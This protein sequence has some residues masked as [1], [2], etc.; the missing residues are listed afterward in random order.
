VAGLGKAGARVTG[1][2]NHLGPTA[3][4]HVTTGKQASQARAAETA[5]ARIKLSTAPLT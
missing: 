5:L 4:K 1:L 3:D 2:D